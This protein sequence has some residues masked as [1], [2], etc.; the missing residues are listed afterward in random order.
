LSSQKCQSCP[1]TSCSAKERRPGENERAFEMRQRLRQRMCLIRHKLLVLSGKGGVGKSTVAVNIAVA[2]Q[3][4]GKR[5]GLLDADIHGPS[6]PRLL[7]LEGHE[8]EV[9]DGAVV[10]VEAAGG[11]K[12]MSIGF[13]LGRE[14]DTAVIW[15]GPVKM[16]IIRQF[17]S[18]VAWGE[19]DYLV[20]DCPPGTGDE[21]ITLVQLLED[22][23][24]AVIVTTPQELAVADVRRSVRFC[25]RVGLP[26]LGVVENMSGFVCPECGKQV[27][28]FR[29]GGG[30]RL[31]GQVGVP[32]LGAIPV[33]PELVLASDIGRPYVG[34]GKDTATSR[35]F[36]QIIQPV[37]KLQE[38]LSAS[39]GDPA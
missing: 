6:I 27:D 13:L 29:S 23:A 18:D 36:E 32:F 11:L 22:A 3:Q 12:V 30:R 28:I 21:P 39:Q 7:G 20:V 1:S 31:A 25:R 14:P 2:L 17:L 38:R 15:R 16:G 34:L 33:E 19:L 4:A 37:L 9:R 8:A 10:P 24:G 26:V 35:A 5:V